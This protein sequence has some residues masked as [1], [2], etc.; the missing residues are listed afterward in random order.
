VRARRPDDAGGARIAELVDQPE[1]RRDR[2]LRAVSGE[3]ARLV[4]Q[5]P[6][7]LVALPGLSGCSLRRGADGGGRQLRIDRCDDL[8]HD[9]HWVTAI[10]GRAPGASGQPVPVA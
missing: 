7:Q 9:F 3:Q 2:S 10:V 6:G 8:D 5:R 4:L 1:H